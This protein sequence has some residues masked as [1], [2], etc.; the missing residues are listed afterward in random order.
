[1]VYL[2]DGIL[3]SNKKNK[4]LI[5]THNHMDKSHTHNVKWKKPDTK[6]H[7]LYYSIQ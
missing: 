3:Y 7:M 1:M 2:H 5:D 6:E 4:L